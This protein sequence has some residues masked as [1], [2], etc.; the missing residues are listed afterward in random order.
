[1]ETEAHE[2]QTRN[3]SEVKAVPLIVISGG[4]DD[5]SPEARA[6]KVQERLGSQEAWEF[7]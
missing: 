1:M 5:D 4:E 2:L 7:G 6:R 3:R